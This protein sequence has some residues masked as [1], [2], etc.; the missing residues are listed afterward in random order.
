MTRAR[1]LSEIVNSTGLSVDTD[2]LVVDSA[3]NRVG[4]GTDSPICLIDARQSAETNTLVA[5]IGCVDS[6]SDRVRLDIYADP[7]TSTTT[8]YGAV[9]GG[10]DNTSELAFATR[11]GVSGQ[12]EAMRIDDG[13]NLSIGSPDNNARKVRIYGTGDLLQLTS[14]NDGASGAQLDLTHESASPADGDSVGII[15]FGGRDSGL[16]G[17]QSANITGKV[18]SVSTETGELHFGTRTNSTTY[19]FSKMIL[20]ASGNLLVGKDVTTFG[21]DGHTLWNDGLV[22]FSRTASTATMRVNKN[23]NDGDLI[24]FSKDGTTVGSIGSVSTDSDATPDLYIGGDNTGIRLGHGADVSAVVPCLQTTGALRDAVTALGKSD[25]RFTDLFLSGTA[26]V[27]SQIRLN[28]HSGYDERSIGLD[29]T[30]LYIYNVTDARYDL[31]IDGSGNLLV[32]KASDD[33]GSAI[34]GIIRANGRVYGTVSGGEAAK[35]NRLS[36]DGDIVDF[37][38]DGTAVGSI[39]V[40]SSVIPYFV[41]SDGSVGGIALGGGATK[42]VFPCD[43]TGA[44]ADNAMDLGNT[45]ARWKDLYLSGSV[46]HTFDVINNGST[47]YQFSDAGSNWF[48]TAENDPVLYLRRGETYIFDVNAS[49]H[50][51]EIRVSNG[52]AAYSTGVTGNATQVGQ[53]IFKVSMSAPSTL[54]YQC[55][56]HS[57]MGNT[58]NI[59]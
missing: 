47:D 25:A 44:G 3:N 36:S 42:K 13:G 14:T 55:T 50:P 33:S 11:Q 29:S 32:G 15:N 16:N 45:A 7:S 10:A 53:V 6:G 40:N 39:G 9:G 58:I 57:G 17:F 38:K 1:D 34:G 31:S 4:I 46:V 54:Y 22:D 23:S 12:V 59:V 26:N 24:S 19:G 56:V 43:T 37:S 30:G 27:G 21:N 28:A 2:T 49:G 35:F 8:L 48:P 52:G 20:D 51:F 41:R 18:G 5:A